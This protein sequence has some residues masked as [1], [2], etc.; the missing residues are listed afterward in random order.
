MVDN[1]GNSFD[2][3]PDKGSQNGMVWRYSGSFE[4]YMANLKA[5]PPNATIEVGNSTL[6]RR[7]DTGYWVAD[8]AAKGVVS[9]P[10][11][12]ASIDGKMSYKIK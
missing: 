7:D 9:A 8:L 4:N 10:D 6:R 3:A 11:T 2:A 12:P 5:N 1:T